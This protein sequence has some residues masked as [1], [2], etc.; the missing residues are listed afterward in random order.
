MQVIL[1][2]QEYNKLISQSK[3]NTNWESYAHDLEKR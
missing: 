3:Q 2:E 1:T